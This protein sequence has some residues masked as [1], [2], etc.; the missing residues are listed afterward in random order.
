MMG[1]EGCF[2]M[3]LSTTLIWMCGRE[4][5]GSASET[6]AMPPQDKSALHGYSLI[7]QYPEPPKGTFE[8]SILLSGFS[9]TC[10]IV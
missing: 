9:S 4:R 8:L 6:Q 5:Q 10:T 3:A 2:T 7:F 1:D